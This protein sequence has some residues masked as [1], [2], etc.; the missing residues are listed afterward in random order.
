MGLSTAE[1]IAYLYDRS[2]ISDTIHRYFMAL[3]V[4][5]W[6]AVRDVLDDQFLIDAATVMEKVAE[7][8][9]VDEFMAGLI[10]R[11]GGFLGT[12]HL[13]PG[14]IIEVDGDHAHVRAHMYCPHWVDETDDGMYL[15][16]GRY[17]IDLVRRGDGWR[18][19]KLLIHID[20]ARGDASSVYA[21]AAANVEAAG[22]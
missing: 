14:H 13:N 6:A 22:S 10:A 12:T 20:G 7:P 4:K 3:D 1:K 2:L 15:A 9:P 11:N 19:T 21:A 18:M 17:E 16:Y 5:D 8:Q